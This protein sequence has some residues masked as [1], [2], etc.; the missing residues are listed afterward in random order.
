MACPVTQD[1]HNELQLSQCNLILT[2]Y[3]LSLG[4][5]YQNVLLTQELLP[6]TC[7]TAGMCLS[8]TKTMHQQIALVTYDSAL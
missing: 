7:S 3:L 4:Q 1:G 5:Y 6:A 8:Y 2:V